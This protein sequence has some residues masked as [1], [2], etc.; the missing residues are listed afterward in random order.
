MDNNTIVVPIEI[1]G[2]TYD[3]KCPEHEKANLMRS[4]AVVQKYLAEINNSNNEKNIIMTALKL[5]H[6]LISKEDQEREEEK[7]QANNGLSQVTG[8]IDNIN[9]MLTHDLQKDKT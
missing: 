6:E 3:I 8:F 4:A 2:K 1:A 5:A 7:K 9:S